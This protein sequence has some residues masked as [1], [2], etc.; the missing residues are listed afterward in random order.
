MNL[1]IL[2]GTS[3][4]VVAPNVWNIS[5]SYEPLKQIPSVSMDTVEAFIL[6]D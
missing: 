5:L 6:L 4:T 3:Y 1:I 2:S